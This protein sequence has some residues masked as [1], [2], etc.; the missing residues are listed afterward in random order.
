[1]PN[2]SGQQNPS[3]I[4]L[5]A[6]I[7]TVSGLNR[8]A[9]L[10]LEESLDTQWIA[11]EISNLARPGS[12]HLYFSLKDAEAQVR[13][14]MFRGANRKLRFAPQ[15]GVQVIVR[16]R[17]TLYEPRGSY[18]LVV[19]HMEPAGE[20]LLRRQF[21]ELKA[22]LAAEGLFD[23]ANKSPLPQLPGRIGIITSQT[24]AAVRDILHILGRRFPAIPVIIYPVPVQG[25][26]AKLAI[27][28]AL[29]TATERNECDILIV[30]RG[31]G[32]LEDLWAFNEEIVARAIF[33]CSIPIISAVGHEVDFTIADLVADVRA[34]TPSA[35]AELIVPDRQT[36]LDN[37]KTLQSRATNA[38]KRCVNNQRNQL[39]QLDGRLQRRN[40]VLLL[41]QYSQR[42]DELNGRIS[43]AIQQRVHMDRLRLHNAATRIRAGSPLPLLRQQ[44]QA[45]AEQN[46]RLGN[47]IRITIDTEQKRLAVLAAGL[48]AVSP[49]ETLKRGYTIVENQQGQIVRSTADLT[50]REQIAGKLTDGRFTA[51]VD[52]I[53]PD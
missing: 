17:V 6:Q 12:G 52:K 37:L 33:A 29:K 3:E 4:P 19:E 50:A 41:E 46:L 40:P 9:K 27:A 48:Q 31:G 43:R 28:Q 24:G 51:V 36:W 32:S 5:D 20:G 11:G 47:A 44:T 2:T 26:Q 1:M 21:E 18:Q 39:T 42:L 22:K 35:A 49:L 14:A 25:E 23:A 7:Y 34:P 8:A 16:A 15:D 30:G 53:L 13:C 38:I 45:L 10:A